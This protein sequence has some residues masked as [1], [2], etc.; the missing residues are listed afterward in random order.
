[1]PIYFYQTDRS[2]V[3]DQLSII[4]LLPGE[5]FR[6]PPFQEVVQ[7]VVRTGADGD[8]VGVGPDL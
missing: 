6:A 5:K 7:S 4:V 1:M 2:Y 8:L 3:R